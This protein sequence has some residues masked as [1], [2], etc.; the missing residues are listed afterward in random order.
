MKPIALFCQFR[1]LP[2]TSGVEPLPRL[3]RDTCGLDCSG[4]GRASKSPLRVRRFSMDCSKRTL[5]SGSHHPVAQS[6]ETPRPQSSPAPLGL[7]L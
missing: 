4:A 2:E 7:E 1:P 6:C 3:P 5:V